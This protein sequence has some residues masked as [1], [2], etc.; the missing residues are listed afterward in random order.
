MYANNNANT[1]VNNVYGAIVMTT[2]LQQFTLDH[3]IN[4]D[5]RQAVA[6]HQRG[7]WVQLQMSTPTITD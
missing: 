1:S 6:N 4:V 2:S 5:Q 3:L 7:L